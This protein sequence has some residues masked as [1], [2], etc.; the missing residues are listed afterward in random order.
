MCVEKDINYV[1]LEQKKNRACQRIIAHT[2]SSRQFLS[3]LSE[4]LTFLT[5]LTFYIMAKIIN[6][7]QN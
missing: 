5:F 2:V 3:G 6:E 7:N 1:K 4:F